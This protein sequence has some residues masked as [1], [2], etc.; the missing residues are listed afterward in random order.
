MNTEPQRRTKT[1]SLTCTNT[2][3]IQSGSG[4]NH[5]GASLQSRYICSEWFPSTYLDFRGIGWLVNRSDVGPFSC[6]MVSCSTCYRTGFSELFAPVA[7]IFHM[8]RRGNKDPVYRRTASL[9]EYITLHTRPAV[10]STH[11]KNKNQKLKIHQFLHN[12]PTSQSYASPSLSFF[13]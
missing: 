9:P 5:A 13:R 11:D 8:L 1:Y 3:S 10:V 12:Q 7:F 6:G 4:S 2:I